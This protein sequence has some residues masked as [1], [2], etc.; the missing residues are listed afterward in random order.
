MRVPLIMGCQVTGWLSHINV[1]S[2][3]PVGKAQNAKPVCS[4]QKAR[5]SQNLGGEGQRRGGSGESLTKNK[6]AHM[7]SQ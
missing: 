4:V 5:K 3:L 6:N 2:R 1:A 7:L